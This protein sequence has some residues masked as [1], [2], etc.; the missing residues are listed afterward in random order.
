MRAVSA[1]L[2]SCS[3]YDV[4]RLDFLRNMRT[5]RGHELPQISAQLHED[6]N[7]TRLN[8]H[9]RSMRCSVKSSSVAASRDV[10]SRLMGWIVGAEVARSDSAEFGLHPHVIARLFGVVHVPLR[11]VAVG[12]VYLKTCHV[13]RPSRRPCLRHLH[14]SMMR[15]A[16][17]VAAKYRGQ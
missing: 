13:L 7:R 9:S 17:S 16:W 4:D 11:H 10:E 12:H 8:L 3:V 5:F 1:K 14:R 6:A 2:K 15:N